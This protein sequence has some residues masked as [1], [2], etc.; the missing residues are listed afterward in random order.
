MSEVIICIFASTLVGNAIY[1][2]DSDL[3][4]QYKDMSEYKRK[5]VFCLLA[6]L[7]LSVSSVTM[8]KHQAK[9]A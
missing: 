2:P 8:S 6:Q 5:I 7:Q 3:L 4:Q 9:E 1:E